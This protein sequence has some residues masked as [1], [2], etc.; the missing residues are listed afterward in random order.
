MPHRIGHTVR[1]VQLQR[2]FVRPRPMRK[3]LPRQLPPT[4]IRVVYYKAIL[5]FLDRARSLV[6]ERVI[7]QLP[8][9]IA[10]E[11]ASRG[12]A[13]RFDDREMNAL[14]DKLS[15]DYFENLRPTE[16]EQLAEQAGRD[17][18][19]F[20][21]AQLDRQVKA[22]F[23]VDV[24]TQEPRLEGRLASWVSENVALIKSIPNRYFDDVEKTITRQVRAG[25][26]HE[27][28]AKELE[29]RFGASKRSAALVA[30]DQ[31]GKFYADVNQAR[32]QA[33]GLTRYVW[34]TSQ[35]NR[36]REEHEEREGQTF[37][38]DDPPEDGHPGAPVLCRCGAE[39]DFSEVLESL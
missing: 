11:K 32:Q 35:D 27:D 5:R 10:R 37:S 9:A 2:Q 22:A 33:L 15:E 34:R 24:F 17:T 1:A 6:Q 16:I 30:R 36:V 18:A 13:E 14:I 20:Q 29:E 39:P 12:D 7:P 19:R 28:I 31:V 38:W 25:V 4:S 21:K 23:G 3:R 26:R 8:A